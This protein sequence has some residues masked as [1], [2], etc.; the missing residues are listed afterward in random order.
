MFLTTNLETMQ[1]CIINV[2]K[3][4]G[5]SVLPHKQAF[6]EWSKL[7]IICFLFLRQPIKL[8][9]FGS[10]CMTQR[11]I[12]WFWYKLSGFET[13]CLGETYCLRMKGLRSTACSL[14]RPLYPRSW[15]VIDSKQAWLSEAKL[16][17]SSRPSR[18]WCT[19]CTVYHLNYESNLT[20][21]NVTCEVLTY[22][23]HGCGKALLVICDVEPKLWTVS[24]MNLSLGHSVPRVQGIWYW[25][26]RHKYK[27]VRIRIYVF[28]P[29]RAT[30]IPHEYM[31][32]RY[33]WIYTTTDPCVPGT[34]EAIPT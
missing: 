10:L 24:N 14:S 34:C 18:I 25:T 19:K 4:C 31:S 30:V 32:R 29:K 5:R 9:D 22:K 11:H 27:T 1:T 6:R 17:A 12:V 23:R 3:R 7:K 8:L 20:L 13:G 2:T 15:L 33:I 16:Q 21:Y 26:D 28:L